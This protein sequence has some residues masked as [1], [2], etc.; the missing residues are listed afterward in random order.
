V[1]DNDVLALGAISMPVFAGGEAAALADDRVTRS[2]AR[3]RE[4]FQNQP[5]KKVDFLEG[6]SPR[7]ALRPRHKAQEG[8]D[9]S[10]KKTYQNSKTKHPNA[11]APGS[12]PPDLQKK[13]MKGPA[14]PARDASEMTAEAKQRSDGSTRGS[15]DPERNTELHPLAK[16]DPPTDHELEAMDESLIQV[17]NSSCVVGWRPKHPTHYIRPLFQSL[18]SIIPLLYTCSSTPFPSLISNP[19]FRYFHYPPLPFTYSVAI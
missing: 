13:V 7:Y 15:I 9:T 4:K 3:D 10:M 17:V 1:V 11:L 6:E 14:K 8:G 16:Q 12:K 18:I 5:S 2:M 19:F